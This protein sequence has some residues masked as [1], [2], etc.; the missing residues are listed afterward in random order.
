M[1]CHLCLWAWADIACSHLPSHSSREVLLL[2]S[3]L[4]SC[5][6]GSI[7]KT[8]AS[9]VSSKLR[10]SVVC[11]AAETKLARDLSSQTG[12]SF[13]VAL[14]EGHLKDLIWDAIT[15]PA[16]TSG[17]PPASRN[18]SG[19]GKAPA[20]D[21][22]MMGFPTRLPETGPVTLCACHAQSKPEGFLCPRCGAKLC[23]VPTDCDV[24]GLLVVSSPHLA[25]SYHHL[26]PV[27]GWSA[28][29]APF[30]FFSFPLTFSQSSC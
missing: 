13:G 21:L 6:P 5:D 12:G 9:L 28:V 18:V 15:P 10:V 4:T 17:G 29:C 25:R 23:D 7:S 26:F 20:S 8:L 11:L 14:N 2:L 27:G 1:F 19:V 16:L 22:M 30:F 3:S 24:C